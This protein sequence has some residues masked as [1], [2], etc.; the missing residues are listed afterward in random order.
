ATGPTL[1]KDWFAST[2]LSTA[3][4]SAV[5]LININNASSSLFALQVSNNHC[6]F[7]SICGVSS[8]PMI[9]ALEKWI[10]DSAAS[11]NVGSGSPCTFNNLPLQDGTGTSG[12]SA[13]SVPFGQ[14]C[15]SVKI[16]VACTNGNLNPANAFATCAPEAGS[17]CSFNGQNIPSGG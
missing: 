15:D 14:S 11:Q 13:S 5:P 3:F 2:N 6:G 8:A 9:A 4:D 7:P 1:S 12:Y 10:S 17:N 16:N